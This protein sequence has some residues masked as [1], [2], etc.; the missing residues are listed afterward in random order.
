MAS[1]S[2]N[3]DKKK[4]LANESYKTKK[5]REKLLERFKV[6]DAQITKDA[7]DR[8]SIEI[9][10]WISKYADQRIQLKDKAISLFDE[11]QN[12]AEV[13]QKISKIVDRFKLDNL[14]E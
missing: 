2:D 4:D 1:S 5:A 10:R 13:S 12:A 11:N 8:K 14:S 6:M 3:K 9:H 7:L